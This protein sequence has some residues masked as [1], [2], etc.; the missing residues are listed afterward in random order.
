MPSI[1][2]RFK[3][4]RPT[5]AS[6]QAEPEP[7]SFDTARVFTFDPELNGNAMQ[8]PAQQ[9]TFP[10]FRKLSQELQDAIWEEALFGHCVVF[11]GFW[12]RVNVQA[13]GRAVSRFGV[14]YYPTGKCLTGCP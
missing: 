6:S 10:R 5:A 14:L 7:Y 13:G 12:S 8:Q 3:S 11:A 1:G 4:D 9:R 2:P